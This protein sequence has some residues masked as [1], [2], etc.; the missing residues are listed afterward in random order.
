MSAPILITT[1]RRPD[2]LRRLLEQIPQHSNFVYIWI[3]GPL[4]ES[5]CVKIRET[6]K[7]ISDFP[8]IN[9]KQIKINDE[10]FASG[11][12]I[13]NAI[14]WIFESEKKAI[15]LEDDIIPTQEF[16]IYTERALIE[17]EFNTKIG[18]IL[19][20]S[21]VPSRYITDESFLY[22]GSE[23]VSSWGWATWATKWDKFDFELEGWDDYEKVLPSS[24]NTYFGK[25]KWRMI[26]NALE[27]GETDAWD[28]KWQFACWRNGYASLAPNFNLVANIGF[29]SE[30]TH[31][32]IAPYWFT[33]HTKAISKDLNFVPHP[34]SVDVRADKW[35]S[36]HVHPIGR[37]YWIKYHIK[38]LLKIW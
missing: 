25:R 18:S 35:I 2:F 17:Y 27:S 7:V 26:F 10:H 23:F 5:D 29:T 34:L 15:I 3:N 13:A 6:V 19:G 33:E 21:S 22:R 32:K 31:T 1:F 16:F 37:I 38:N 8:E 14:S 30:A 24:I 11:H 28:Y 20:S 4:D 12:S 36:K 9:I